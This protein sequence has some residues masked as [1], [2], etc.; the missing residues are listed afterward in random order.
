MPDSAYKPPAE[1]PDVV[2]VSRGELKTALEAAKAGGEAIERAASAR[3]LGAQAKAH[4]GEIERLMAEVVH[5]EKA[6]YAH[7]FHKAGWMFGLSGA[8]AGALLTL[9]VGVAVVQAGTESTVRGAVVGSGIRA[10]QE[11]DRDQQ[12]MELGDP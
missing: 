9:G 1:T 6:A 2:T 7:G 12:R 3:V 10:Q 11:L 5:R 4:E 8:I